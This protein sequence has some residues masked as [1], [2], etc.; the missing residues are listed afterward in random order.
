V[1]IAIVVA[2][3]ALGRRLERH[4]EWIRVLDTRIDNLNKE[5]AR[6]FAR[7]LQIPG[8]PPGSTFIGR[9]PLSTARPPPLSDAETVEVDEAMLL[10]KD[11]AP[12]PSPKDPKP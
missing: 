3:N 2:V 1:L 9:R 10:T 8:P 12:Y 6:N 7:S 11:T 4:A 5:R